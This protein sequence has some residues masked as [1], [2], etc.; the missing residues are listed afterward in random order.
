MKPKENWEGKRQLRVEEKSLSDQKKEYL[1]GAVTL[2]RGNK[3][4][5]ATE[6]FSAIHRTD[7]ILSFLKLQIAIL[8]FLK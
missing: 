5:S 7:C 2:M 1:F 4:Q 8:L 3:L 6:D